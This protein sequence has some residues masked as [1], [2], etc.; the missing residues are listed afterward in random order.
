MDVLFHPLPDPKWKGN[1]VVDDDKTTQLGTETEPTKV[2]DSQQPPANNQP[3]D[4]NTDWKAEAE[5][6]KALSR[7]NEQ[8]WR[9]A[10]KAKEPSKTDDAPASDRDAIMAEIRAEMAHEKAMDRLELAAEKA[11]LNLDDVKEFISVDKFVTDGAVDVNAIN[12]FVQK[13]APKQPK[14]AQNVG[15][16]PQGGGSAPTID[17]QIA[18]AEKAR[19]FLKVIALKQQKVREQAGK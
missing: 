2:D 13:I 16:G 7:Q 9:D 5:K 6:W 17:Q 3:V 19:D 12:E 1:S 14:F 11:S 18:E 10:T 4:D 15:V 8:K